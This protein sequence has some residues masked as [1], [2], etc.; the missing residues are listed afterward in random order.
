[1]TIYV[2]PHLSSEA[3]ALVK[4]FE[5]CFLEAYRDPVGV[6]TI[7]YGHT[8]GVKRG[9]SLTPHAAENLLLED[10]DIAQADVRHNVKVPLND[11]EFGALVSLAF[12]I[13]GSALAHSTLVKR[14]N[15]GDRMGAAGEFGCFVNGHIGGRRVKLKGL[16]LRR[17]AE[18]EMFEAPVGS[19]VQDG[20]MVLAGRT[21][22]VAHPSH[23]VA[24]IGPPQPPQHYPYPPYPGYPPPV[25][26][27]LPPPEERAAAAPV[28]AAV[29]ERNGRITRAALVTVGAG[30]AMG[31][32]PAT[33][34]PAARSFV[35]VV[36]D[37]WQKAGGPDVIPPQAAWMRWL[38]AFN[39]GLSQIFHNGAL[40]PFLGYATDFIRSH[41]AMIVLGATVLLM[42]L[43]SGARGLITDREA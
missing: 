7:G 6:M 28:P 24:H 11:N 37:V 8:G 16:V 4:H 21:I 27:P 26:T 14:L 17:E 34:T 29:R 42:L 2:P 36:S 15:R 30:A 9:Q 31:A 19:L 25:Y 22:P 33:N 38:E 3:L 5:G 41:E 13:G 18:R 23:D 12:N 43:R 39:S 35:S 10:L 20:H 40:A 1:M 32:V